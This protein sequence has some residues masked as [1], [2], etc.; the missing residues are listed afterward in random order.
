VPLKDD[1]IVSASLAVPSPGRREK[2]TDQFRPF[3]PERGPGRDGP[4]Q[5]PLARLVVGGFAAGVNDSRSARQLS[6][7]RL[8]HVVS[9]LPAAF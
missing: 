9:A 8:P 4:G 2:S 7:R 5:R 6:G 1:P 3:L